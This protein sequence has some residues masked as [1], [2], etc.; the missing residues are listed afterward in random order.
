[1][2]RVCSTSLSYQLGAVPIYVALEEM[3][4]CGDVLSLTVLSSSDDHDGL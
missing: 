3:V 4:M 1:M 2:K